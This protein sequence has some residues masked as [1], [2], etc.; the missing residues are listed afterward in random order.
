MLEQQ[1]PKKN[2][3]NN[4]LLSSIEE[5]TSDDRRE[6]TKSYNLAFVIQLTTMGAMGGFLFG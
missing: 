4:I 3:E 6:T 1:L 5:M 2:P